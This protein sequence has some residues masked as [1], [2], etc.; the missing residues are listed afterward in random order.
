[1]SA[2]A[3]LRSEGGR[4]ALGVPARAPD[5]ALADEHAGV[6]DGLGEAQLEDQGLQ[7]TLQ[8]GLRVQR[9]HVI[10]LVLRLLLRQ[11]G[12][13]AGAQVRRRRMN[14]LKK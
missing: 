10:Q 4:A 6:V 2:H 11:R 1:M 5:V 3:K 12:A 14:E 13:Q 8:E 9:Q 7:P